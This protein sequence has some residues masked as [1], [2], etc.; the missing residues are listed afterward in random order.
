MTSQLTVVLE[1]GSAWLRGGFG[2]EHSP[3]FVLRT[4]PVIT[5]SDGGEEALR[6]HY[7]VLLTRLFTVHL[8]AKPRDCRVLVVESLFSERRARNAL[9]RVLLQDLYVPSLSF[10]PD[11]FV[12]AIAAGRKQS[13]SARD[14]ESSSTSSSSSSSSSSSGGGGEQWSTSDSCIILDIGESECRAVA[15]AHGRPILQTLRTGAVGVKHAAAAFAKGLSRHLSLQQQQHQQQAVQAHDQGREQYDLQSRKLFEKVAC[16][17]VSDFA[18]TTAATDAS[19]SYEVRD[20]QSPPT[21]SISLAAFVVPATLRTS[22][23]QVLVT[24]KETVFEEQGEGGGEEAVDVVDEVGGAAG[25]LLACLAACN[26][27]V[28]ALCVRHIQV[29]GGG[30]MILN[31][32]HLVCWQAS[33]QA[34]N[35]DRY[36]AIR[37]SLTSCLPKG[38]L[39]PAIT[40]FARCSLAW[41]GGS[42]FVSVKANEAKFVKASDVVAGG[43][44]AASTSS[45]SKGGA[46]GGGSGAGVGESRA[47]AKAQAPD[48]MSLC[49]EHWRFFGPIC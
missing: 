9:I 30:A 1:F 24:G 34:S 12:S 14:A 42:L 47:Q 21:H 11:L 25:V 48:W 31:L 40:P 2:G 33:Q 13:K 39:T 18:A 22:C 45:S 35:D 8:Q 20:I 49:D 17:Q 32:P 23:L 5:T 15:V 38:Y 27:D 29:Q 26:N 44:V 3:R 36:L 10:Q 28:R 4:L 19:S 7:F 37:P 16:A 43:G 46:G 6:L 41:V